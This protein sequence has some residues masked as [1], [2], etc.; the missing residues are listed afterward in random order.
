MRV[1][2]KNVVLYI[3]GTPVRA[4][5]SYKD[6]S[7]WGSEKVKIWPKIAPNGPYFDPPRSPLPNRSFFMFLNQ[8]SLFRYHAYISYVQP[9]PLGGVLGPKFYSL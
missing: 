3:C 1:E 8:N 2:H 6:S 5:L 7:G 9:I 4:I